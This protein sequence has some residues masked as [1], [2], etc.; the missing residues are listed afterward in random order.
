MCVP[1]C[2]SVL[3]ERLSR[4]NF[5]KGGTAVLAAAAATTASREAAAKGAKVFHRV[6]DLSQTL[7]PDFPT[8]IPEWALQIEQLTTFAENGFNTRRYTMVEHCGTHIDAPIHFSADGMTA[9][10]IPLD[11]LIL[12]LAVIDVREQAAENPDYQLTPD[13]LTAWEENYGPLPEG[14]CVAMNS[15]WAGKAPGAEF[16]NRDGDG[17]MHFPG[18]HIEATNMMMER[19]AIGMASDT[20]SLDHGASS[21]FDTHYAWLPSGRWGIEC[22]AGLDDVPAAGATIVVAAPKIAGAT[23]GNC[24]IMALV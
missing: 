14:A 19:G 10:E 24:R 8:Y 20:L 7:T 17:V 3:H 15:G 21:T 6:V 13:D 4:R 1:G 5:F 22:I 9:D 23:G 2:H 16:D 12:P 11:D 18:F